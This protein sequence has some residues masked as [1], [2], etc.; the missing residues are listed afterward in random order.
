MNKFSI[1]ASCFLIS[2]LFYAQVFNK[3]KLDAYLTTLENHNKVMGSFALSKD[4]QLMYQKTIGFSDV[5]NQQKATV[6]TPYRVGSVT[7]MLTAT[8]VMKAVEEGKL[9]LDK[10]LAEFYPQIPNADKISIKNLLRH[11]SGIFNVTQE[12]SYYEW[13]TKPQ[14]KQ[15][16]IDRIASY[17]SQFEPASKTKYSNSNYILLSYILEDVYQSTFADLLDKK[18]FQPLG[19]NNSRLGTD[20]NFRQKEARSYFFDKKWME[21]ATTDLSF[22]SGAGALISTTS[23]ML[24]F[25]NALFEGKIISKQ[26]LETMQTIEGGMGLGMFHLPFY[27]HK[28]FAH[29]GGIDKFTAILCYFPEEKIGYA[30]AVNGVAYTS[31]NVDIA[32]LSAAFGKEYEIPVFEEQNN[33]LSL[34]KGLEGTYV[35]SELPI[36]IKVYYSGE[37]LLAQATGQMPFP[38]TKKEEAIYV[39]SLANIEIQ[40]EIDEYK[41]I[42]K[43]GG[44]RFVFLKE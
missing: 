36:K 28:A 35:S 24:K 2:Q 10:K 7:K 3:Q 5:Q 6:E 23:D 20:V 29:T 42:L 9:K 4:N 32:L 15:S 41:L 43:Q 25:V 30:R 13:N 21:E 26:S 37:Q 8:L 31:N 12:Y 14:T 16:M 1:I 18:I 27:D 39:Y 38:L 22:V 40:F 19:M 17:E 44:G 33:N 34:E 11:R